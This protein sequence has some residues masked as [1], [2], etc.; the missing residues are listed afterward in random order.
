MAENLDSVVQKRLEWFTALS[1][2]DQA[3]V[4]A[5]KESAR[6]DEAVK[7]ERTAEMMATFQAA[8]TNQDG[9]LDIT[10]FEDFMTKLSQNATARGIPTMSPADIDEEMKQKVWGLFNAEGSADGVSPADVGAVIQKVA[11]RTRELAGQ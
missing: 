8:D 11:A 9:L 5:D 4:K 3:K 6:T 1:A 2:E 7:A 10:E